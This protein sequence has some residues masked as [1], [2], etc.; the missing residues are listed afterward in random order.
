MLRTMVDNE[1]DVTKV[2]TTKVT[3]MFELFF[4][5]LET[6]TD[7]NQD[8]SNWDAS[9]LLISWLKSVEVSKSIKNS[10]NILVTLVVTTLV[11]SSSLSTIVLNITSSTTV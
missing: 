9:Q 4:I 10:S 2:V 1:E 11:T 6:S 5:D 7:F 3:N 8:I